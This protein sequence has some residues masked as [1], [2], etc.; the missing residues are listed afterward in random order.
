MIRPRPTN[1]QNVQPPPSPRGKQGVIELDWKAYFYEFCRVHGPQE[2]VD[3]GG[4]LLFKDGWTYSAFA[5]EGPEWE[6]PSNFDELDALVV[7]YWI[8]RRGWLEVMLSSLVLQLQKLQETIA[9]K[10]LPL[11]QVVVKHDAAGK[12][13]RESVVLTMTGLEQRIKWVRDDLCECDVRLREIATETVARHE[14]ST[15]CQ[16]TPQSSNSNL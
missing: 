12:Q 16:K 5:Y 4:R 1:S 3:H 10:S 8:I 14:R 15:K 9:G 2:P 11:R 13:V 6:P 7:R